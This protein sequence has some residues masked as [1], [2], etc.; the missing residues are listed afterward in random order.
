M[1][2]SAGILV[3]R[4]TGT[5]HEVLLVHPGGPFWMKKDVWGIPKG[6][7]EQNDNPL[8]AAKREFGEEIGQ[9]APAGNYIELG[10]IKLSGGK[11]VKAWAVQGDLD[12]SEVKSN[13]FA[14]EWPPKSGNVQQFPE[15]DRA[16]WFSLTDAVPRMHK[17]QEVFI[18]TLADH[19]GEPVERQNPAQSSLF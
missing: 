10:E 7:Y 14:Q 1:K 17:G 2:Q 13:T 4:K 19:L 12:T 3:F 9:P 15:V 11:L 5:S 16:E 6:L 18:T 8:D